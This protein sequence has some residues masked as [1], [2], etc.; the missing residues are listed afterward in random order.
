MA[1]KITA[2]QNKNNDWKVVEILNAAGD[3]VEN[4]SVN[5]TNKKGEVFPGFDDIQVGATIEGQMWQSPAG[6][7]YLFAPK[8]SQNKVDRSPAAKD[9][10][11]SELKNILQ[12]Q[13]MPELTKNNAG[14]QKVEFLIKALGN[15]LDKIIKSSGE[16]EEEFQEPTF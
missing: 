7:L 8:D 2:V 6:K 1:H 14:I 5:R 13:I 9:A 10:G 15:R 12:L 3:I 16:D 11:S 4:I